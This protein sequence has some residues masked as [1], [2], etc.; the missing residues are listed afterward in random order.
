MACSGT[1]LGKQCM[2]RA[3]ATLSVGLLVVWTLAMTIVSFGG[4]PGFFFEPFVL[5]FVL[6]PSLLPT[7]CVFLWL[8]IDKRPN[9][10]KLARVA[11][12]SV[13][14]SS[15]ALWLVSLGT[16]DPLADFLLPLTL[17]PVAVGVIFAWLAYVFSAKLIKRQS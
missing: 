11:G 1:H 9:T 4:S 5:L 15:V 13:I 10:S 14:I 7:F 17:L 16:D 3:F 2:E 6:L 8:L 12:V